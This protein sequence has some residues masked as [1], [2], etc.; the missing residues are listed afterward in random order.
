MSQIEIKELNNFLNR[1]CEWLV[2]TA[3][4]VLG[5]LNMDAPLLRQSGVRQ[6]KSNPMPLG[7]N[8]QAPR[9]K[10]KQSPPQLTIQR[11]I[12]NRFRYML[13][14]DVL[15][16][17]KS[18]I[19]RATFKTRSSAWALRF[20][21]AIANFSSSLAAPSSSEHFFSSRVLTGTLV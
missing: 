1:P 8:I 11:A 18:A 19:V 5:G 21:S 16:P 14:R 3:L 17:A 15:H 10:R 7:Q 6:V 20:K 13:T 9:G 12:L 4:P 2:T